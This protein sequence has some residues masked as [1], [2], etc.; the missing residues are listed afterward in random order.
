MDFQR[1]KNLVCLSVVDFGHYGREEK[2]IKAGFS[3]FFF[4]LSSGEELL[5]PWLLGILTRF[6]ILAAAYLSGPRA[7]STVGRKHQGQGLWRPDLVSI[8]R[9][10]GNLSL[11]PWLGE[12]WQP[13]VKPPR[14]VSRY[15][16]PGDDPFGNQQTLNLNP[17]ISLPQG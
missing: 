11:S 15:A 1:L 2:K 7:I 3:Q 10:L 13:L 6:T 4:P 5:G 12:S 14:K 16:V 9:I 8:A 17:L